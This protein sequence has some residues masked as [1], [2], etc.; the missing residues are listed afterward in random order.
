MS[1]ALDTF[2]KVAGTNYTELHNY[3]T[4]IVGGIF[5]V[6]AAAIIACAVY[7]L[8]DNKDLSY[9]SFILII[10]FT[11]AIASVFTIFII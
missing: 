5:W 1:K 11:T 2:N 6:L 4:L 7:Q 8:H 10:M 9:F 3:T